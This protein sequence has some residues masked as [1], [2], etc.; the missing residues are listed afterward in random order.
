MKQTKI[1]WCDYTCNP[2]IGCKHNCPYCYAREINKRFGFV[3]DFNCPQFFPERLKQFETKKPK[4]IFVD[5]MSDIAFWQSEWIS[6]VIN[7][8]NINPHHNYIFL[9]KRFTTTIG[10]WLPYVFN[11]A[12]TTTQKAADLAALNTEFRFWSVEPILEPIKITK[13]KGNKL[14][15]VIIGAETGKRE[16]KVIPQKEWITSIVNECDRAGVKVFMKNSLKNIMG[17]D[18][19]QDALPW[20]LNKNKNIPPIT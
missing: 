19:R 3:K 8:I 14:D 1:E 6:E 7:A 15:L 5:S 13:L 12:T 11:G 18:F 9:T 20:I 10:H 2:V 16:G 17:A 4:S